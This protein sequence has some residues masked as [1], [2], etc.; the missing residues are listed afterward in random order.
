[1]LGSRAG[2]AGMNCRAPVRREVWEVSPV[3]IPYFTLESLRTYLIVVNGRGAFF[4]HFISYNT[5]FQRVLFLFTAFLH[6][7][8][9]DISG[10]L[11]RL[12]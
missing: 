7:G 11:Y 9:S 12:N 4:F 2:I 10:Q 8:S 5:S 6:T 3:H 1:M